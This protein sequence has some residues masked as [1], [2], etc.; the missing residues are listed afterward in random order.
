MPTTPSTPK[1]HLCNTVLMSTKF[2]KLI[3]C[4][5][6]FYAF[7]LSSLPFNSTILDTCLLQKGII[8]VKELP[9]DVVSG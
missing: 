9:T 7:S 3:G 4:Q 8:T 6:Y 2:K 1:R 5:P